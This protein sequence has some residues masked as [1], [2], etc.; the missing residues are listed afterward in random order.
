MAEQI[1][2]NGTSRTV[3][4]TEQEASRRTARGE[5]WFALFLFLAV[6]KSGHSQV[7]CRQAPI[8]NSHDLD[9]S[10]LLVFSGSRVNISNSAALRQARKDS[11][12]PPSLNFDTGGFPGSRVMGTGSSVIARKR[13]CFF[14]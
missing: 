12:G 4:E 11:K 6:L 13:V 10:P 1:T 3:K 2:R 9:R 14:Q 7:P 5:K 8:G